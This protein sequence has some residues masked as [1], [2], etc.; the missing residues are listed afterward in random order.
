MCTVCM[1]SRAP[2]VECDYTYAGSVQQALTETGDAAGDFSTSYVMT[3]GDTFD[4]AINFVGDE[5]WIR[6]DLT[7]GDVIRI[8]VDGLIPLN[9]YLAIYDSSGMLVA[10]NNDSGGFTNS[11]VLIDVTVTG[12]YFIS[13]TAAPDLISP[14]TGNYTISVS[15]GTLPPAGTADELAS[16]LTDDHWTRGSF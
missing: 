7:A 12:S 14:T 8:D 11:S 3:V 1:A 4:G 16:Y 5:D 6:I 9:P 10:R 15:T 13:V 2:G